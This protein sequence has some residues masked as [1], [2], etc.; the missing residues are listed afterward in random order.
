MANL[1]I[2]CTFYFEALRGFSGHLTGPG[3]KEVVAKRR[4]KTVGEEY[5]PLLA[6]NEKKVS[7]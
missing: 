3:R 1:R 2:N 7:F 5:S 6:G 4:G